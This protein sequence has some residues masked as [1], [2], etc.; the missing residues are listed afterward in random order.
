MNIQ[1]KVVVFADPEGHLNYNFTIDKEHIR[2]LQ[3]NE[4]WTEEEHA[5]WNKL[6]ELPDEDFFKKALTFSLLLN[7]L[8]RYAYAE[9]AAAE[10]NRNAQNNPLQSEENRD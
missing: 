5:L 2:I 10:G 6:M 9:K 1:T 8:Y 3:E 7:M 4:F